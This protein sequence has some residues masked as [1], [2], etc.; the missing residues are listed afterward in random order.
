MDLIYASFVKKYSSKL[1][2]KNILWVLFK[3]WYYVPFEHDV[4]FGEV[5]NADNQEVQQKTLQNF[6][7]FGNTCKK[8][9][10]TID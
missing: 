7:P 3:A 6:V 10:Q 9:C 2:Q 5:E 1:L 4:I 8:M